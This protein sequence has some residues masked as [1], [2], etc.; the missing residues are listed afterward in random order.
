LSADIIWTLTILQLTIVTLTIL[1]LTTLRLRRW[2][3]VRARVL[4]ASGNV[5]NIIDYFVDRG[6]RS[7]DLVC[8]I[9]DCG[10]S[11]FCFLRQF[12]CL[13][14]LNLHEA[15]L[16]LSCSCSY[17]YGCWGNG[18]NGN[19]RRWGCWGP[20][21]WGAWGNGSSSRCCSP[22]DSTHAVL[23]ANPGLFEAHAKLL[24]RRHWHLALAP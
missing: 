5:L 12:C 2:D 17:G 21:R 8:E 16:A 23:E 18:I 14:C 4:E 13:A 9:A 20:R 11:S 22:I 1:R 19:V 10:H 6:R 7:V 3:I 15:A 24:V